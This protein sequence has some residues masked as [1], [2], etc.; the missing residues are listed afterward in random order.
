MQL[1]KVK[2]PKMSRFISPNAPVPEITIFARLAMTQIQVS[3]L[4]LRQQ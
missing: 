4:E 1:A 2:E 3:V